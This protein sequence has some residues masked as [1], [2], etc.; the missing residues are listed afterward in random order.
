MKFEAM[1]KQHNLIYV[2]QRCIST[3]KYFSYKTSKQLL[4]AEDEQ[5]Y[6]SFLFCDLG[7]FYVPTMI[8]ICPLTAK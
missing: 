4:E 2:C 3:L 7:Q 8:F 6:Q 5:V 1:N